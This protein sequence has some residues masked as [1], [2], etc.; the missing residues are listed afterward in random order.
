MPHDKST[1]CYKRLERRFQTAVKP[2]RIERSITLQDCRRF[3][4]FAI[5][6]GATTRA[7][8]AMPTSFHPTVHPPRVM[9]RPE[10]ASVPSSTSAALPNLAARF[11]GIRS[12]LSQAPRA[13]KGVVKELL[14]VST[15]DAGHLN[16]SKSLTSMFQGFPMLPQTYH[17]P[18]WKT[19]ACVSLRI[20]VPG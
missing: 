20:R 1:A 10:F 17:L 5:T 8:A 19:T 4:R 12:H 18:W 2:T 7:I 13:D 11:L 3:T 16:F 9:W 14:C 15:D 6:S